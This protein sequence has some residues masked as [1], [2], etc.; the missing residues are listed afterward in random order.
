MFRGTDHQ[1]CSIARRSRP[2]I[3]PRSHLAGDSPARNRFEIR[4]RRGVLADSLEQSMIVDRQS[5]IARG[6]FA[7]RSETRERSDPRDARE[8]Q[9]WAQRNASRIYERAGKRKTEGR[10]LHAISRRDVS[11]YCYCWLRYHSKKRLRAAAHSSPHSD[12]QT[13]G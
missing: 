7:A 11:R 2:S 5:Y 3:I 10:L 1:R 12:N 4:D 6:S 8:E 9:F 13:G